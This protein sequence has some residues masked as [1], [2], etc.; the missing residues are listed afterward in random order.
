MASDPSS[1]P[2]EQ[3]RLEAEVRRIDAETAKLAAEKEEIEKRASSSWWSS[4]IR[5]LI[6]ILIAAALLYVWF[7]VQLEPMQTAKQ[8]LAAVEI[9]IGRKHNELEFVRNQVAQEKLKKDLADLG[10]KNRE[11]LAQQEQLKKF[12]ES[13]IQRIK[14]QKGTETALKEKEIAT[15]QAQLREVSEAKTQTEQRLRNL[16]SPPATISSLSTLGSGIVAPYETVCV[17]PSGKTCPTIIFFVG[18]SC[19]CGSLGNLSDMGTV[20]RKSTL[21]TPTP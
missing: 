21:G 9:E 17:T 16:Q 15:L 6:E 14:Q 13:S 5:Y 1:T 3:L 8:D 4:A 2:I 20:T 12:Y 19:S 7:K 11:V 18:A 10:Q